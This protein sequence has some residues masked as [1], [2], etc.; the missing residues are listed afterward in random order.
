MKTALILWD[1]DNT[2]IANGG[3]SKDN[4]AAA[5]ELL[6]GRP[7]EHRAVTGGST[8]P[9]IIADMFRRHD[10]DFTPEVSGRLHEALAMAMNERREELARRGHELPGARAA[11]AALAD[12]PEIVQSVL[13]GNIQPNAAAKVETFDLHA[14]LD[15]EVGGYGSDD[16]VRAH[17]VAVAQKRAGRKYRAVFNRDNT[18][19]IGDTP[20]DVRA[21]LAGGAQV[22]GVASGKDSVEVL[23]QEGAHR[24]L[25]DLVDTDAVLAAL[26]SL[27]RP[28]F[29]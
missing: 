27:L 28:S 16:E 14:A 13:T 18:V 26:R 3:V 15:F 24:V 1:V 9:L 7:A 5:F 4:Y 11:L 19:L 20:N 21:G 25:P 29:R 6:T 8:D 2:L 22:L 10:V 12:R 17:L 23:K